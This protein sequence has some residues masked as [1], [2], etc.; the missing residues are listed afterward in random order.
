MTKC[1]SCGLDV[2]G[3]NR[4]LRESLALARYRALLESALF[5]RGRGLLVEARAVCML[6]VGPPPHGELD[7]LAVIDC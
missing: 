2:A 1:A 3:S 7:L 6:W 5:L 4:M